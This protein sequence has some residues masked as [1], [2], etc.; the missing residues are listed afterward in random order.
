MT[1]IY[2]CGDFAV[3]FLSPLYGVINCIGEIS[4]ASFIGLANERKLILKGVGY[5]KTALSH[6]QMTE[7]S[8]W[9]HMDEWQNFQKWPLVR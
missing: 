5:L 7:M 1:L 2:G 9:N 4:Q 8:L 6:R 3:R